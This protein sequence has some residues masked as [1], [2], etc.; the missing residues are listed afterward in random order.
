MLG[1]ELLVALI[2]ASA[3]DVDTSPLTKS[4]GGFVQCYEPD[5]TAKTCRSIAAY[6]R[7]GA[8]TWDNIA[9]VS[10][11]PGHPVSFET[12]TP[13]SVKNGAVCGYIRLAD[14]LK[15]KL[16]VSGE[17]LPDDKAAPVLAKIAAA[18][19]PMLNREI[20]TT[21]VQRQGSLVATATVGGLTTP[22]P[23]QR[24]RWILPSDGY[25]VGMASA[26]TGSTRSQ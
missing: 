13:V 10:I 16:R 26:S 20:C 23:D 6:R 25:T 18:M 24:V 5:D 7:S 2:A 8:G 9:I 15:G 14:L 3:T 21:Y 4:D 22:V 19:A 17:A 11:D 1:I 12:I